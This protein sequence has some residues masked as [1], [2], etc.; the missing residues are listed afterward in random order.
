MKIEETGKENII[1]GRKIR[2]QKKVYKLLSVTYQ[3]IERI[4]DFECDLQKHVLLTSFGA[5][6]LKLLHLN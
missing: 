5:K 2:V 4:E 6:I 1:P 3:K